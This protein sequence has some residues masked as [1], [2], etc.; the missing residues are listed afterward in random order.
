MY[1]VL[2]YLAYRLL[3]V[4]HLPFEAASILFILVPFIPSCNILFP[5]GFIL[6]ERVLYTPSVG[7]CLGLSHV[8]FTRFK[9]YKLAILVTILA[10]Y[11]ARS[12]QHVLDFRTEE[13]LYISG[14]RSVRAINQRSNAHSIVTKTRTPTLEHRYVHIRTVR[15][16]DTTWVTCT[17]TLDRAI[18]RRRA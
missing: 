8:I 16:C 7:F 5:V 18:P 13:S 12:A 15:T 3:I 6:A 14:V 17:F 11:V 2:F 4:K 1:A 10:L 9:K